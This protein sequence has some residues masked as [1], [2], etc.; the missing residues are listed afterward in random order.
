M[1]PPCIALLARSAESAESFST[2][3]IAGGKLYVDAI[4]RAGG[5]PL[6]VPPTH[7]VDVIKTTLL[8]CD[9]VLVMGGGDVDPSLYGEE[10]QGECYAINTFNDKFEIAFLLAAIALDKPILAICRGAQVL[11]VALGGTL[12]QDLDNAKDHK[13]HKHE[14][15]VTANTR[16][17]TALSGTTSNGMSWH[18][19]A[20]KSV[21]PD[22][23]CVGRAPDGTIEA[24]EHRTARW[25]LGVQWH[26]EKTAKD[27]Q[28]Q[29][30]IFDQL[31]YQAGDGAK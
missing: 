16:L 29:Q 6:L 18:H 8:R 3:V 17:A 11:N 28:Q 15:D 22:L 25:V 5:I 13:G 27:D 30:S 23:E 14:V 31:I 19:Q 12:I 7:D 4:N 26:P 10:D 21:A 1:T 20:I 24:V 2:E 9:G